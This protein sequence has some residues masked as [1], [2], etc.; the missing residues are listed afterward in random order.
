MSRIFRSQQLQQRKVTDIDLRQKPMGPQNPHRPEGGFHGP[1][2]VQDEEHL[3]QLERMER[4]AM[5]RIDKANQ[6]AEAIQ[7]EAYQAGFDQGEK[8]GRKLALQKLEPTLNT[9]NTLIEAASSER[10]RL[11][12]QHERDLIKVA[13]AIAI[14]ILKDTIQMEPERVTQ[15]VQAALSKIPCTRRSRCWS[16]RWTRN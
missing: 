7:R 10:E 6:E 12:H 14:E 16:R 5:R 4:D 13:F 11:I 2:Q 3:S 1:Q 9:L 8:G 15:V